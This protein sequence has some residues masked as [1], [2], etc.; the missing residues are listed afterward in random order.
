MLFIFSIRCGYFMINYD[1]HVKPF[2]KNFQLVEIDQIM[3]NRINDFTH[4]VIKQ[5]NKESHHKYDNRSHY[6]RYYT[7]TLGEAALEKY[8]GVEGIIDWTIGDSNTYH[9]P[10]LKN[11]GINAGIKTVE[12]GMF[13]IIFK[14]SYSSEVIMIK[15]KERFIYICGLA[16]QSILNKYQS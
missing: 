5:K 4:E 2:G 6:K 14:K 16:T 10:D 12:Y 15:W 9:V 3:I 8:L 11:I 7:G 1:T 13:P